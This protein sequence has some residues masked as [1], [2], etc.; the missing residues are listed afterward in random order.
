MVID[1]GNQNVEHHSSI[2]GCGIR[3]CVGSVVRESVH[4]FGIP[5]ALAIG[6]SD[7]RHRRKKR[8]ANLLAPVEAAGEKNRLVR[9]FDELVMGRNDARLASQPQSNLFPGLHA[10]VICFLREFR[11]GEM[12]MLVDDRRLGAGSTQGRSW[13]EDELEIL[14]GLF[15]TQDAFG[16]LK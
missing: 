1:I 16:D 9:D 11:D 15:V 6:R 10:V 7:H 4:Q 5:D 3:F 14:V 12:T 8:D 2:K 13:R